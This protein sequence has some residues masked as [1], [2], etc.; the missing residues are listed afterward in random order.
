MPILYDNHFLIRTTVL[1][2]IVIDKI[3]SKKIS[4]RR[5]YEDSPKCFEPNIEASIFFSKVVLIFE[6]FSLLSLW[7]FPSDAL[8]ALTLPNSS[9]RLAPQNRHLSMRWSRSMKIYVLQAKHLAWKTEKSR[10]EQD[11]VDAMGA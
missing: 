1:F 7:I 4:M 11:L 5:I 10:C 6:I 9:G 3:H 8:T 2:V